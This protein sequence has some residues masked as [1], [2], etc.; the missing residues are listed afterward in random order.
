MGVP[1]INWNEV[2]D[3]ITKEQFRR[4]CHISKST[5]RFLLKS[6]KVP[7][8]NSGKKTR[9]YRILKSD[10]IAFIE[11]RERWPES[12]KASRNW[13]ATN[14]KCA[15]EKET[16][17]IREDLHEYYVYLLRN[18]PDVLATDVVCE[19]IG[20]AVKSWEGTLA[21]FAAAFLFGTIVL[22]FFGG[23]DIGHAALAAFLSA[24]AGAA[25][26]LFSPS[27]WDTVTVPVVVLIVLMLATI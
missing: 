20:Y 13:Y 15:K 3:V 8:S 22:H 24:A 5:A 9:C 1:P 19:T 6:G 4:L 16:P 26:E 2:P 17:I 25:T 21:M 12:Y 14:G 11:D 27:E 10:V 18:Q 7:C 23:L